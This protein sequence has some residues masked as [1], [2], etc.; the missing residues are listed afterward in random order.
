VADGPGQGATWFSYVQ[1][2]VHIG[3]ERFIAA[4]SPTLF[5][6]ISTLLHS[7]GLVFQGKRY[8]TEPDGGRSLHTGNIPPQYGATNN[9]VD[10]QTVKI[11]CE[12]GNV[13]LTV[14]FLRVEGVGFTSS[15][16]TWTST[17]T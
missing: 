13:Q 11:P 5:E 15:T 16:A 4:V 1:K 2:I 12:Q 3:R 7:P 9:L 17:S 6:N 8:F 14:S 10:M